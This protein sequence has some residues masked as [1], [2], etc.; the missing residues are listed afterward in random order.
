MALFSHLF[1]QGV[2]VTTMTLCFHSS[3][4]A[5][6]RPPDRTPTSA[7]ASSLVAEDPFVLLESAFASEDRTTLVDR[8]RSADWHIGGV[9]HW[10][11]WCQKYKPSTPRTIWFWTWR[12]TAPQGDIPIRIQWCATWDGM[13]LTTRIRWADP[14]FPAASLDFPVWPEGLTM[15]WTDRMCTVLEAH[16]E[17][18]P[19][20]DWRERSAFPLRRGTDAYD[21]FDA[22]AS[23][24][25]NGGNRTAST[26]HS[27]LGVT[28]F[29]NHPHRE[30]LD[31][32]F[33]LDSGDSSRRPIAW[34]PTEQES[35]DVVLHQMPSGALR[36]M[37]RYQDGRVTASHVCDNIVFGRE[38]SM[39]DD[40]L[41]VECT[42]HGVSWQSRWETHDETHRSKLVDEVRVRLGDLPDGGASIVRAL[43]NK[44]RSVASTLPS[45]AP[46][47]ALDPPAPVARN[48]IQDSERAEITLE[49]LISRSQWM[50]LEATFWS[51]V[52]SRSEA[53]SIIESLATDW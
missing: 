46:A 13:T 25:R 41:S 43:S 40:P 18:P 39:D 19:A 33:T 12:E 29:T 3:T 31:A 8:K 30:Q 36:R 34:L 35:T 53:A 27:P 10:L 20:V 21:P 15:A 28:W 44:T 52:G 47:P 5:A 1:I 14:P 26:G 45:V 11:D 22:A 4:A 32:E 38:L 2:I 51:R 49:M 9:M 23:W 50:H 37:D 7:A 24:A 6:T 48:P 17:I 42:S 16:G